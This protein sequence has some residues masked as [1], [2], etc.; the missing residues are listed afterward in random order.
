MTDPYMQRLPGIDLTIERATERTPDR[1]SFHVFY[2]GKLVGTHRKLPAAQ[3]QF[4]QLRD[5][6]GWKPRPKPELTPEEMLIREREQ[7]Q[8]LAHLEYWSKSHQF[9]GGGRPKRK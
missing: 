8:R 3:L 4:R 1:V 5:E 7:H 6:S 9:R 2:K